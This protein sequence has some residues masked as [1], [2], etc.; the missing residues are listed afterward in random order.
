MRII[1]EGDPEALIISGKKQRSLNWVC[2]AAS[3]NKGEKKK[4]KKWVWLVVPSVG[5]LV[6]SADSALDVQTLVS[7]CALLRWFW[8]F[9][10]RG[11]EGGRR[12]GGERGF[13]QFLKWEG[14]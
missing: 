6:A 4:K 7:F 1:L 13:G 3:E 10:W 8:A 12:G 14:R 9:F 5:C 11:E 2:F